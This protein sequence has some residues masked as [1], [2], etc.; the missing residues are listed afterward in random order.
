MFKQFILYTVCLCLLASNSMAQKILNVINDSN[1]PVKVTY[2]VTAFADERGKEQRA[3]RQSKFTLAL[4][5]GEAKKKRIPGII[6]GDKHK[7][8]IDIHSIEAN[9]QTIP[10]KDVKAV[11]PKKLSNGFH[12][13]SSL[14]LDLHE[15]FNKLSAKAIFYHK[16]KP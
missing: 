16:K 6:V 7:Y 10:G 1:M 3:V 4:N 14:T 15:S 5:A 12:H 8:K 2:N 13:D 9:G 11:Y